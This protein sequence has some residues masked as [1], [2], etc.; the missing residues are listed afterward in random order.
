MRTV[1][2]GVGLKGAIG[3]AVKNKLHMVRDQRAVLFDSGLYLD[4]RGVPW[5]AGH[6][7]LTVIHDHL[8]RPAALP[9]EE[10]ADRD[11]HEIALAAEVSADVNRMDHQLFRGDSNGI[12]DLFPYRV[13]H[14]TARPDLRPAGLIRLDHARMGF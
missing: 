9:G 1:E 7:L 13:G 5:I 6:K 3:T 14:F 12:G 2:K 4:N 11:I 8:D 10:V